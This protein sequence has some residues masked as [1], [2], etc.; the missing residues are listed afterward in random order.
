MCRV[1]NE[2]SRYIEIKKVVFLPTKPIRLSL[3]K[4]FAETQRTVNEILR[5]SAKHTESRNGGNTPSAKLRL[6]IEIRATLEPSVMSLR[7]VTSK[8][9]FSLCRVPLSDPLAER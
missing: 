4:I 3:V 7:L 5:K 9:K 8:Y 6:K 1:N 2:S